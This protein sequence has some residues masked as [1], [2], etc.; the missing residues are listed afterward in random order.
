MKAT[1]PVPTSGFYRVRITAVS[2]DRNAQAMR[3]KTTETLVPYDG[4]GEIPNFKMGSEESFDLPH[5]MYK[6]II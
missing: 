6:Y 1:L 3:S 4:P 2:L 5:Y